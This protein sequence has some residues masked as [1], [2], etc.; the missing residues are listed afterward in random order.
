MLLVL[1]GSYWGAYA[2][3][4]AAGRRQGR[5]DVLRMDDALTRLPTVE[6]RLDSLERELMPRSRPRS[7]PHIVHDPAPSLHKR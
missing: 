4:C 2:L 1:V 5:E 3:G 7:P 6:G